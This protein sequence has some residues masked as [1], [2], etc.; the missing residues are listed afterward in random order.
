MQLSPHAKIVYS[1]RHSAL[2][3]IGGSAHPHAQRGKNNKK[4]TDYISVSDAETHRRQS[5]RYKEDILTP[6]VR[7]HG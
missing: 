2:G 3:R 4:L 6:V 7:F 1:V 5:W